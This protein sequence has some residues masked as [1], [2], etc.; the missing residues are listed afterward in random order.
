MMTVPPGRRH[1][2]LRHDRA[3]QAVYWLLRSRTSPI[4]TQHRRQR[5]ASEPTTTSIQ[6]FAHQVRPPGL[7]SAFA[8]PRTPFTDFTRFADR[9]M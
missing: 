6:I 9:G 1:R 4:T 5:N 2:G 8:P 3:L 7:S